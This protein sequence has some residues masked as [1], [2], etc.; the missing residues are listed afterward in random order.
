[1]NWFELFELR[2]NASIFSARDKTRRLVQAVYTI[3][4]GLRRDNVVVVVVARASAFTVQ[5]RLKSNKDENLPKRSSSSRE[6]P[7]SRFTRLHAPFEPSNA[8]KNAA[9]FLLGWSIRDVTL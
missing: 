7:P 5:G 6:Y 1:M 8:F 2:V 9:S 3:Y 4:L